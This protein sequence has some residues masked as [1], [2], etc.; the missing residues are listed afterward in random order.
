MP[1]H[2]PAV[3]VSPVV[4][5]LPSSQSAPSGAT[6]RTAHVEVPL[7]ARV[8]QASLGHVIAHPPAHASS[9]QTSP[10]VQGLPSVQRVPSGCPVQLAT[11]ENAGGESTATSAMRVA[12]ACFMSPPSTFDTRVVCG[13]AWKGGQDLTPALGDW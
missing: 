5:A 6:D 7:H 2:P 8:A 4:Q 10:Y 9:K 3:Q 12:T 11:W 13:V 1:A